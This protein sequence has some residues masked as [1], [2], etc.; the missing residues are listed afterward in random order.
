MHFEIHL[1]KQFR[2]M[3]FWIWQPMEI[4]M[5][6]NSAA[7]TTMSTLMGTLMTAS[8]AS[9]ALA[10]TTTTVSVNSAGIPGDGPAYINSPKPV[11]A[12]GRHI[13]FVSNSTNLSGADSGVDDDVFAFDQLT[14]TT[15]L[16]SINSVGQEGNGNSGVG[17]FSN[18]TPGAAISWSGRYVVYP[19]NASNLVSGDSN[20][21][22]DIF[23]HNRD[24]S[25]NGIFDQAGDR[26]TNRVSVSTSNAEANAHSWMPS[27]SRSGRFVLFMSH[28]TNLVAAD[29]GGFR[30]LFVRDTYL[31]TTRRV[32]LSTSDQQANG[33]TSFGVISDDGRWVLFTSSAANLV[34]GDTNNASDVFLRDRDI[35][36]DGVYD[37]SGDSTT[38][39][40][41][42]S[43]TGQI[44]NGNSY[45]AGLSDDARHVIFTSDATN[46]VPSD[47][48]GVS[49]VFAWDFGANP[50]ALSRIS[51]TDSI[52]QS[53]G[54]SIAAGISNDGRFA[55]FSSTATNLDPNAPNDGGSYIYRHDRDWDGNGNFDEL[56]A[57]RTVLAGLQPSGTPIVPGVNNGLP[58]ITACGRA[59]IHGHNGSTVYKTDF[60]PDADFDGLADVW[61]TTGIDLNGDGT[62]EITLPGANPNHKDLY[63]HLDAMQGRAPSPLALQSVI[64]SFAAVPANIA[65]NPD[66][67][68]GI[69]L[70]IE[71]DEFALPLTSFNPLDPFGP[72]V[73]PPSNTFTSFRNNFFGTPTERALPNA[74]LTLRSKALAYRYALFADSE[75]NTTVGGRGEMPGNGF[76]VTLGN[77]PI[78]GG[79]VQQQAGLFMH[80]LGHN[81]GLDHGGDQ[82]QNYKP[83]HFQTVMNYAWT[84]PS[85][86]FN[87]YRLDF[88]RIQAPTLNES[89]LQESVGIG[90]SVNLMVPAGPPTQSCSAVLVPT[91]GPVDWDR[92]GGIEGS[93]A[94]DINHTSCNLQPSPGE[95]LTGHN[96]WANIWM[97]ICG[98]GNFAPGI[99]GGIFPILE[100]TYLDLVATDEALNQPWSDGFDIADPGLLG[101]QNGWG[102]WCDGGLD[103]EV[104]GELFLSPPHALRIQAGSDVVR[105]HSTSGSLGI[106]GGIWEFS[107]WT[108]VPSFA[109]GRGYA[110]LLNQYCSPESNWSMQ[111]EFNADQG[112]V[113]TFGGQELPMMKDQWINLR[114]EINLDEDRLSIW[115][116]D[117]PLALDLVW[118]QNVGDTNGNPG[119]PEL[120]AIN[121]YALDITDMFFDDLSLTSEEP[122]V[123]LAD[124]NG[125]GSVTPTDFTAWIDAFNNAMPGCDQNGDGM[126][127][128]TD[129]TA[130]IA[131]FNAGCD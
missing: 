104:T 66:G 73:S 82:P 58:A 69:T 94:L 22:A 32:N 83:N 87:G 131:N 63:I 124:V 127:T 42:T 68:P 123:C 117:F 52:F 120:A 115:Y 125:D 44:G 122:Q 97:P 65:Q 74:T 113:R 99:S 72:P 13:V 30:D 20:N 6:T 39:I 43:A 79:T 57:V 116:G 128:P 17:Q 12:W 80:E 114:A 33:D 100:P 96:D 91:V 89:F 38:Y 98:H 11:S 50:P 21:V 14:G 7:R 40:L 93:P 92:V 3:P 71:S 26:T 48:N 112:V 56:S 9:G 5:Y 75:G 31:Q 118:T 103:A 88:S 61:E 81:L 111:I 101:S 60:M 129:F 59:V 84:L 47:T 64:S 95:Y 90:A 106:A 107:V 102:I 49:D 34:P 86:S 108:N 54:A 130:W 37:Q 51:H 19:S 77:W 18:S 55:T 78:P 24:A 121:L 105:R 1:F 29:T 4:P 15:T 27:V 67:L 70:H 41:S 28:A 126:C 53:N 36:G 110:I 85:S 35:N 62:V 46:L 16:L 25:G 8:M 10:Q 76:Y 45:A 2:H 119:I 23:L 109:T